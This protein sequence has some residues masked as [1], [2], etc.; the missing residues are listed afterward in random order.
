[1]KHLQILNAVALAFGAA[2]GAIMGVVCILYGV[3][4]ETEPQLRAD[5]PRLLGL[6]G[7]FAALAATAALAFLGHRR[8]WPRRWW[9][10]ALPLV[11]VGGIVAF[12][13]SLKG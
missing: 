13:L 10:Q 6:T 8:A 2:M 11:P 1:V 4:L 7:L 9:L 5:M 12:V 3:H